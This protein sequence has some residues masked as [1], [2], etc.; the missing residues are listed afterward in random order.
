[1]ELVDLEQATCTGAGA[2]GEHNPK[3]ADTLNARTFALAE[4]Q[5]LDTVMTICSTCQGVM[6]GVNYRLR[7][8]PQYREEINQVLREEEGLEYKGTVR[9]THMMWALVEEVGLDQLKK[10]VT[11]P[12]R[13]I[14]VAPFYGCYIL[15]PS[16]VLGI[17]GHNHRDHYLEDI[18][19]A[20]GGEPVDYAGKLKCCGFPILTINPRN[21]VTMVA[22]HAG[23]AKE[24]GANVMV[25]PCP[26]CHLNLDGYQPQA[27]GVRGK[28][29]NLPVLH[30]P[31]LI[32]AA[33]G[34]NAK[35]LH[36]KRHIIP[37]DS[38]V[39]MARIPRG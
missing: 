33:I 34:F 21:S 25:T 5:G 27:N 10:M 20:L 31:Q 2:L 14:K 4:R 38:F 15:R 35:E 19:E 1:M 7:E 36:L 17:D 29:I 9:I 16:Y 26:L 8:N 32:G 18:I 39:E 22:T 6:S 30:L 24:K 13:G 11:N 37:T 23:D 3:L 12:L 28:D